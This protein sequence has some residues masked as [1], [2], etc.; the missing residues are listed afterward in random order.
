MGLIHWEEG[1]QLVTRLLHGTDDTSL[2]VPIPHY[3][4]EPAEPP[5]SFL[6]V[7]PPNFVHEYS[8]HRQPHLRRGPIKIGISLVGNHDWIKSIMGA[9]FPLSVMSFGTAM[10]LKPGPLDQTGSL[11]GTPRRGTVFFLTCPPSLV[12]STVA[13]FSCTAGETS[14]IY[15]LWLS[16]GQKIPGVGRGVV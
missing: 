14:L 4:S 6:L 15:P 3:S 2:L 10:R 1:Q 9:S 5:D 8:L 11:L 7:Y 12:P 13:G 16:R